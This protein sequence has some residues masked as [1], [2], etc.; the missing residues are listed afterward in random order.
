MKF[1]SMNSIDIS[2]FEH[3]CK[4]PVNAVCFMFDW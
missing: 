3:T 2:M 4:G 1:Y